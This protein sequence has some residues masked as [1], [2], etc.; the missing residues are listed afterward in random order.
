MLTETL[1]GRHERIMQTGAFSIPP[2]ASGSDFSKLTRLPGPL[3][4]GHE[5]GK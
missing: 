5:V 2:G 3:A 1:H 4:T